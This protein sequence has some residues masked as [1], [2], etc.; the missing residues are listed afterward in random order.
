MKINKIEF[1]P[2]ASK[3]IVF[4][5][6]NEPD[7]IDK[8]TISKEIYFKNRK[9]FNGYDKAVFYFRVNKKDDSIKPENAI[10]FIIGRVSTEDLLANNKYQ[11]GSNGV[12]RKS[13]AIKA[14]AIS[15][16]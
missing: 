9:E 11:V 6:T 16:N 5:D 15:N 4:V 3:I 1:M 2:F 10:S 13:K 7:T 14:Q 8:E 12:S